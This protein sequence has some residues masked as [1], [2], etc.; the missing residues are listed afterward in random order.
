MSSA[1]CPP[2]VDP[3]EFRHVLGHFCSGL[4]IVAAH[5]AGEPVGMT[6]QS[7]MSLSLDPPLI[8]FSPARTS[9]TYPH[10]RRSGGF[11]VNVLADHQEGL[12]RSFGAKADDRWAAIEWSAGPSGNAR[13]SGALAWIDCEIEAEH[14]VGDHYLVVGRVTALQADV[15]SPL[16][17]FQSRFHRLSSA[18]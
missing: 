18:A 4:T 6:C 12:A 5:N 8:G 16:L 13:I 17:F 11:C 9:T 3:A 7:F 1:A 2:R 14:E 15:A 10:I